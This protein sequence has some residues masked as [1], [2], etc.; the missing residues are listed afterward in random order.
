MRLFENKGIIKIQDERPLVTIAGMLLFGKDVSRFLP[1]S[2]IKLVR[3][4]GIEVGGDFIDHKEISGILPEL[5][6]EAIRFVKRH[7]NLGRMIEAMRS[8]DIPE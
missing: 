5:I 3:F 4:K 7:T 8:P 2:C 6:E 1:Q